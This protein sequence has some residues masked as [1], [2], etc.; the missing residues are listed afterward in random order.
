MVGITTW[1]QQ[2]P[3]PT[4]YFAS[5]TNNENDPAS[6][7]FGQPNYWR[8]PLV[9]T[10]SSSPITIYNPPAAPTHFLRGAVALA[11]NGVAIF[12]PANNTG[13][14]SYEIGEL[15]FYGGHCGLADDYHYHIIPT[16]L[17]SRFGG[18]LGDD[19]PVAWGLDGYPI[20][21][22]LE[23][24]GTARQALDAD[25]GHDHGGGWGYHYHA[26]GTTTVDATHPYGTPQSPYMMKNFHGNVVEYPLTNPT[27]VDGQPEVSSLRA[28]PSGGYNAKAVAGAYIVAQ[29]NPAPLVTDGSGNLN[30]VAGVNLTNCATTAG[31]TTVTCADTTGLTPGLAVV[32]YGVSNNATVVSVTNATQFVLS[33]AAIATTTGKNFTAVSLAGASPDM[34]LMRVNMGGV[35]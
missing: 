10:V 4:A 3:L 14:V 24:D 19:K 7:G 22:F 34:H 35:D 31:S 18:P 29:M 21:G 13:Q 15:D 25:G 26:V 33:K 30:L 23:P 11:S 17:N 8:I 28:N 20:Y 32:G 12:N 27:Q 9:P 5:V 16:H 1:Q 2:I 6:L